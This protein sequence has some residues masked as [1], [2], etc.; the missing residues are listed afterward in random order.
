M[1]AAPI[2]E[3]NN[4]KKHYA[5]R[6]GLMGGTVGFAPMISG[7]SAAAL[8]RAQAH[9]SALLQSLLALFL[10]IT[11]TFFLMRAAPGGPFDNDRRLPPEIARVGT[12]HGLN[13]RVPVAGIGESLLQW[14]TV[15]RAL[16]K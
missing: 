10:V 2:L 12:A 6:G 13:E 9:N 5:I 15:L 16:A 4:L 14:D 3:V 7:R 8:L 11:A 1:S